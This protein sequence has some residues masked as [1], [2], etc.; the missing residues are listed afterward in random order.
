MRTGISNIKYELL[1]FVIIFAFAGSFNFLFPGLTMTSGTDEFGTISGAAFAAGY[2]WS[3]LV[4]RIPYYG[5]GYSV[6]MTPLFLSGLSPSAIY[7][8]MLF[9]NTVC[10]ALSGVICYRILTKVFESTNTS[11][12]VLIAL[13]AGLFAPN[14]FESNFVMNESMLVLLNWIVLYLLLIMYKRTENGEK[15]IIHS[16]I[17]SF[18]LCYGLLVHTRMFFVWGAV[19]VFIVLYLI[20]KKKLIVNLPAFAA[21]LAAFY[22]ISRAL[23][24][25]VQAALWGGSD[26]AARNTVESLG[27]NFSLL[28]KVLTYDGMTTA[29]KNFT[30]QL[31]SVFTFTGGFAYILF[32]AFIIGVVCFIIPKTRKR[33]WA[34]AQE[35]KALTLAIAYTAVQMAAILLMISAGSIIHTSGEMGFIN[36]KWFLYTRYW[37]VCAAP[38][39]MLAIVLFSR[40]GKSRLVLGLA[41]IMTIGVIAL[42][43]L[44]V[45]PYL[46]GVANIWSS[47]YYQYH[48]LAL[49]QGGDKF[50]VQSLMIITLIAGAATVL[51]WICISRQRYTTAVIVFLV[52]SLYTYIYPTLGIYTDNSKYMYAQ[53]TGVAAQLESAGITPEQ[54]PYIYAYGPEVTL[55]NIQFNLYMFKVI[56]VEDSENTE[57]YPLFISVPEDGSEISVYI[58]K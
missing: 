45:A 19:A 40:L 33:V 34:F 17:L 3:A 8:G 31:Y 13:A 32:A 52:F 25:S 58:N 35:N 36:T 18:V 26:E 41:G 57:R 28:T 38:A 27:W 55:A 43:F 46:Y 16:I 1:V 44:K 6:L 24:S 56:P 30:G 49:M 4:S 47:I 54:Q 53:A 20:I 29:L 50:T 10:L 12:N 51:I 2:D 48:G 42:F 11:L 23:I 5:F 21:S 22:L 14:L 9:Y 39:A 37:A 15:N 7:I